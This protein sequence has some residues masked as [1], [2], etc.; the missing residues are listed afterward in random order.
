MS[1]S[2]KK[3]R[4]QL[5]AIKKMIR[6]AGLPERTTAAEMVR[7]MAEA[8]QRLAAYYEGMEDLR[9]DLRNG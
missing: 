8:H 3:R 4:G 7:I 1:Q 9:R 5:L 2:N 6:D